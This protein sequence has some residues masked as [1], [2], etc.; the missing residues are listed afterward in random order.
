MSSQQTTILNELFTQMKTRKESLLDGL[1]T[2]PSP[3]VDEQ[4]TKMEPQNG[5]TPQPLRLQQYVNICGEKLAKAQNQLREKCT[6]TP[7]AAVLNGKDV[8]KKT[9]ANHFVGQNF[10][11]KIHRAV[12]RSCQQIDTEKQKYQKKKDSNALPD[13]VSAVYHLAVFDKV[14]TECASMTA[15]FTSPESTK[16]ILVLWL[17]QANLTRIVLFDTPSAATNSR[18]STGRIPV[19]CNTLNFK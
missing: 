3:R 15:A 7:L 17:R 10:L 11:T 9:I 13:Q 12:L 18:L 6:H 16:S 8:V 19:R 14:L 5:T 2:I 4:L 1:I